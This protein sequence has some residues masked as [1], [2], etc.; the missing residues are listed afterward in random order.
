M[1]IHSYTVYE[2]YGVRQQMKKMI[3]KIVFLE[4][5]G[6]KN[7][8]TLLQLYRTYCKLQPLDAVKNMSTL[9]L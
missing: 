1:Y 4:A 6:L 3:H 9:Q 8:E 5:G 2:R 7:T